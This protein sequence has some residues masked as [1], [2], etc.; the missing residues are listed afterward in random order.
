MYGWDS[1]RAARC[2]VCRCGASGVDGEIGRGGVRG[3]GTDGDDG[4]GIGVNGR[5]AFTRCANG[6]DNNVA[7]DWVDQSGGGFGWL[8]LQG[9]VCDGT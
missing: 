5:S 6:V 9:G 7:G 4:D 1:R 3:H 8:G 2:R